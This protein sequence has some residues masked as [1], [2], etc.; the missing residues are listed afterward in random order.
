[1]KGILVSLLCTTWVL[2]TC[3]LLPKRTTPVTTTAIHTPITIMITDADPIPGELYAPVEMLIQ[4]SETLQ[5]DHVYEI[6]LCL[7]FLC[8]WKTASAGMITLM[9]DFGQGRSTAVSLVP[10]TNSPFVWVATHFL[11]APLYG[12]G[13]LH[14]TFDRDILIT[15]VY[16]TATDY[17]STPIQ[18][19]SNIQTG[20][21]VR[22]SLV[23]GKHQYAPDLV[24]GVAM[25]Q[26]PMQTRLS[27][28][29][30]MVNW[31]YV[32][33]YIWFTSTLCTLLAGYIVWR[34]YHFLFSPRS[35]R[36]S[37]QRV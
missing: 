29:W 36:A 22:V 32:G 20:Y 26:Q 15:T 21:T 27:L 30:S 16:M 11:M 6:H 5:P 35:V 25:Y 13:L 14:D 28:I 19:V 3:T 4:G 7:T 18:P 33:V 31:F 24:R 23:P 1:M 17:I 9:A 8:S 10:Y 34:R 2:F 12:T 37:R